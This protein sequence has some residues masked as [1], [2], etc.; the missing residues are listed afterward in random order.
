MTEGPLELLSEESRHHIL[1]G[2]FEAV[3]LAAPAVHP[4]HV[5]LGILK[6]LPQAQF[7]ALFPDRESF[8]R[9][10]QQ[11]E[12]PTVPAPLSSADIEYDP[13]TFALVSASAAHAP[14][15]PGAIQPLHLLLG[16]HTMGGASPVGAQLDACGVTLDRVAAVLAAQPPV[17]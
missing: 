1:Q 15:E 5:V 14:A 9:F 8:A 13:S 7:D 17:P 2:R 3:G 16:A 10:C 4:E 12:A 6:R 11:L